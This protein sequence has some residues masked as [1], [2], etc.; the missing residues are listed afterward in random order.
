MTKRLKWWMAAALV[1]VFLAGIAT[2]LFAGAMHARHVFAGR[3]GGFIGQ[4]MREHLRRELQL[5]PEQYEKI[6]PIL[7]QTSTRL[8]AIREETGRRVGEAMNDSHQQIIPL[9]TPEQRE[10]LDRMRER[11]RSILRMRGAMPPP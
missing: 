9:L 3:H 2:G 5:T 1:V 4:R 7:D 11:H 8:D 10:K 6:A